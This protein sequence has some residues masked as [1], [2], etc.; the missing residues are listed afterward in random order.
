MGAI[1]GYSVDDVATAIKLL[2][3]EGKTISQAT[4]ASVLGC[5]RHHIAKQYKLWRIQQGY[6]IKEYKRKRKSILDAKPISKADGLH[7]LI[8]AFLLTEEGI[9]LVKE[10]YSVRTIQVLELP[11][12]K[13]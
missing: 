9:E 10:V 2:R 7:Q 1:S 5:Q 11:T 6:K 8:K 13:E 4:I 12:I 3:D